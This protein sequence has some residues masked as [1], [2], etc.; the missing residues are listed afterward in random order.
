MKIFLVYKKK[1]LK[2]L[3]S[4]L[5]FRFLVSNDRN[6]G[7]IFSGLF[8]SYLELWRPITEQK[9]EEIKLRQK[10]KIWSKI[11]QKESKNG[12]IQQVHRGHDEAY[13]ATMRLLSAQ[14][15]WSKSPYFLS[16]YD[17]IVA[18]MVHIVPRWLAKAQ[19]E[20]YK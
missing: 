19:L 5:F 2:H 4:Y 12:E 17:P 14:D 9:P 13:R 8:T 7:S 1:S 20:N 18:T 11:C 10:R 15:N 3:F 6:L 16:K